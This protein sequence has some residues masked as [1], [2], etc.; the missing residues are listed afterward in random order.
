MERYLATITNE[1]TRKAFMLVVTKL[2]EYELEIG[3]NYTDFTNDDIDNFLRVKYRKSSETTLANVISQLKNVYHFT[4]R[5]EAVGHLSLNYVR[6]IMTY[7]KHEFYSPEEMKSLIDRLHNYQDKALVML[8]YLGLYDENFST[9]R[10]LKE[11]QIKDGYIELE[12]GKHIIITNYA[13]E[14]LKGAMNETIVY[15][16]IDR[17]P[18]D[19]NARIQL[20][21]DTG[22][23]FRAKKVKNAKEKTISVVSLKKK[24]STFA[25]YLG[26]KNFSPIVIKNSKIIYD[27][28]KMELESNNGLDL[29]QV[30]LKRICKEENKKSC[31]EQ[32]N[33]NKK[34]IK[35]KIIEEIFSDKDLF[36]RQ[37]F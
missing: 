14:L 35:N 36:V 25:K 7:K 5:K 3:K 1:N 12:N 22:Y 8:V 34:Q 20:K 33:V 27:L 32:L 10:H 13:K 9:I 28:V 15:K 29:N 19:I 18:K 6:S 24:F 26:E 2:K 4:A 16:Y 31:I 11:S 30:E 37:Q 21:E 17:F 23:V